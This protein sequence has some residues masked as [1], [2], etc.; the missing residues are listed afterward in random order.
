MRQKFSNGKR[1]SI[2]CCSMKLSSL[3]PLH[4]LIYHRITQ[5]ATEP[6]TAAVEE[7]H[8]TNRSTKKTVIM[9]VWYSRRIL[10]SEQCNLALRHA[11]I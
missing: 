6:Y 9:Q 2:S 7:K 5:P 8:E 10:N 11:S 4:I 3:N 1:G